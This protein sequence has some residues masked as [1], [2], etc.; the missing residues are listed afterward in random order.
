M[1]C[2][3]L[4]PPSSFPPQGA[5][6]GIQ[7]NEG[8]AS[9]GANVLLVGLILQTISYVIFVVLFIYTHWKINKLQE[10]SKN[11][12]WRKTIWLLYVSSVFILVR[13]LLFM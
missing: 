11:A 1:F 10:H 12:F 9:L 5:G 4:I 6:G 13:Y 7:S 8:N 3:Y 2:S